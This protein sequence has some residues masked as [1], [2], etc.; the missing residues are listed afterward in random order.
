MQNE[1]ESLNQYMIPNVCKFH[2]KLNSQVYNTLLNDDGSKLLLTSRDGLTLFDNIGNQFE[3]TAE[4]QPGR[5]N[6]AISDSDLSSD[7]RYLAHSSLNPYV[8][9]FDI[10]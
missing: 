4:I 8:S 9:I 7:G 10:N 5:I 2:Q 3:L 6:W 1:D